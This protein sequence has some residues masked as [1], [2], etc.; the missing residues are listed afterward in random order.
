VTVAITNLIDVFKR[1]FEEY[2]NNERRAAARR[3][4]RRR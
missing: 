4:P 2:A 3:R 1:N